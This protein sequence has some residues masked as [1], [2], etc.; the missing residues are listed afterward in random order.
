[1]CGNLSCA[2]CGRLRS[3]SWAISGLKFSH[4][5]SKMNGNGVST[6][7]SCSLTFVFS[8]SVSNYVC[9]RAVHVAIALAIVLAYNKGPRLNKVKKSDGLHLTAMAFGCESTYLNGSI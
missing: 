4:G 5:T 9:F 2:T 7:N 3:S 1:M 8:H 6:I